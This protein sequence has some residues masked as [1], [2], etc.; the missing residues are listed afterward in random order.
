MKMCTTP[1]FEAPPLVPET[2]LIFVLA[3]L[4]ARKVFG[5]E[6]FAIHKTRRLL[7]SVSR[8]EIRKLANLAIPALIDLPSI[9]A[10]IPPPQRHYFVWVECDK[11]QAR[12]IPVG[13]FGTWSEIEAL[14]HVLA[15]QPEIRSVNVVSSPYH[16]RRIRLCCRA[17]LPKDILVHCTGAPEGDTEQTKSRR[18]EV[19]GHP[20]RMLAEWIKLLA[21]VFLSWCPA[22]NTRKS[23][24]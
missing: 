4:E 15:E 19:V 22:L 8:F 1:R 6:L 11:V 17:L 5:V 12:R 23:K 20:K 24:V 14:A 9:A 21:Y 13:R 3:G 18:L 2:D 16:L 10:P 7:L